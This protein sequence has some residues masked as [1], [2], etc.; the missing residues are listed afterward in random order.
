MKPFTIWMRNAG[1]ILICCL[2]CFLSITNLHAASK[3]FTG[4]GNFSDATKWSGGTLPIAGDDLTINGSCTVNNSGT[5]DNVTYGALIVGGSSAG[6]VSWAVSGTNRLRVTNVSSAIAGSSVNMTNGGTFICTGTW[7]AT[8]LGFTPGTGTVERQL[9]GAT[10]DT[11]TTY[12]NLT[13]N[14]SGTISTGVGITVNGNLTVTAGTLSVGAFAFTVTGNT[15]V[16]STLSIAS[17]TGAKSFG[18]LTINGTLSNPFSAGISIGG[19]L[20]NNGTFSIGTGRVTFTGASSATVSGTAGTTAFGG[21]ITV[22]K[23]STNAS[24]LDVQCGITMLSGGLTLTNGTF[25]LSSASTITPFTTNISSPPYLIPST[26]GLWNNGGTMNGS[27][28]GVNYSGMIRNSAGSMTLGTTL[29]NFVA[30]NTGASMIIEG[31]TVSLADRLSN[32]GAAWTFSMTGGTLTVADIGSNV[33]D[34]PVFNMDASGCSFSMSGGTIILERN[35]GS[36]GQNLG[37]KNMA[38][39]GTGFTGGTLQIGNSST[40]AATIFKIKTVRSIYNLALTSGN[41]TAILDSAGIAVTNNVTLTSGT[42]QA[43][44]LNISVGGNWTNN[45]TFTPGTG[46]V[47]FNGSGAQTIS[48]TTATFFYNLTLNNATGVSLGQSPT[49]TNTLSLANGPLSLNS[50]TLSITNPATTA[51]AHTNGYLVSEMT[52]HS[53]KVAWT[54]GSTTGVHVFPFGA[55]GDTL[56]LVFE[57]TAGDVGIL[58]VSTYHTNTLNLP[59][60]TTPTTVTN[61]GDSGGN[62]NSAYAVDRFWQ[63]ERT[64]A[65]GTATVSFMAAGSECGA[66]EGLVAQRWNTGTLSWD[67]PLSGQL[68]MNRGV[69][70]PGVTLW[71]S[72]ALV[73]SVSL[74]PVEYLKLEA[75]QADEHVKIAWI[76]AREVNSDYFD[77]QR[78]VD[79]KD[80]ESLLFVPAAGES[81]LPL[82][83]EAMD[84]NPVEGKVH[85][86]LRQVDIDGNAR[87]SSAVEV[88]FAA[89]GG[90]KVRCVPNPTTADQIHLA[91]QGAPGKDVT[92]CLTDLRGNVVLRETLAV[93]GVAELYDLLVGEPLRSGIYF[94]EATAGLESRHVR[95][96]VR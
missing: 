32:M 56:P 68:D 88:E 64:G 36:A 24:V 93:E 81:N 33:A 55:Q 74:L 34:R 73:S 43:N 6:T 65:S 48:G 12:N 76:T 7:T 82:S 30:P 22:N 40:P 49:V 15:T 27:N 50:N 75:Y 53:G 1:T 31:G 83:Y 54:I 58:T 3:T 26:A 71:G 44:N 85:Y 94:V 18:N 63:I 59:Y 5:T 78:S 14:S 52:D 91:I 92:I 61:M 21:G 13:I 19:N 20:V 8:N 90:W 9:S 72:Y 87:V 38:A 62:D 11:Y 69:T 46:T 45:A 67:E 80:F 84:V 35:G 86:R 42:L 77:V 79:G 39:G 28:M 4:P 70:V 10:L 60:P 66:L 16:T 2:S 41:A 89:G 23:G 17:A 95:L 96:V 37:Y 29:G 51:L 57:L 47:T 25:K